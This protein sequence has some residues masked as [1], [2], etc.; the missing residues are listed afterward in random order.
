QASSL[1]ELFIDKSALVQYFFDMLNS[2]GVSVF[3]TL[4]FAVGK[5]GAGFMQVIN[6]LE[7]LMTN[8]A[9][10]FDNLA[11]RFL[12][13]SQAVGT[14]KN[15]QK[16]ADYVQQALPL[17][18]SIFGSTFQGIINLFASFGDNSLIIFESLAQMAER[19]K[20]WSE[21]VKNSDGF[22]QFIEYVQEH[23]PTVIDLIGNIIGTIVNLGI[24]LAPLGGVVLD[25]VNGF[26]EFTEQLLKN[27]P[28]V[29]LILCALG[30]LFGVFMML[31]PG[32]IQTVAALHQLIVPLMGA[33]KKGTLL[34]TA[35]GLLKGAFGAVMGIVGLVIGVLALLI[36]S[37]IALWNTNEDFRTRVIEIWNTI[38]EHISNAVQAISNFIR[39][40]WG[41]VVEW[42]QQNNTNILNSA[43]EIWT[44]ILNV[45]EAAM[46]VI[47]PVI[48][49]AWEKIKMVIQV[50]LQVILGIIGVFF[51]VLNGD[52]SGAWGVIK[53]TALN[54]WNIIKDGIDNILNILLGLIGT[55]VEGMKTFLSNAWQPIKDR[56]VIVGI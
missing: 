6:L 50:T 13:W 1:I 15:F 40:I 48:Q 9:N 22:K 33:F 52:W 17:I 53:T 14:E 2:T 34:S 8:M 35:M 55:N 36:G 5:F 16:F 32:I 10:G 54:I 42:W 56:V 30:T 43:M 45:V 23:G 38:K 51:A 4:L 24:A 20:T 3:D 28:V 37:F 11:E 47:V 19:F 12:N 7:P 29:G 44:A 18:G 49:V 31:L 25:V 27:H 46:A 39:E 26:F 21:T 41:A